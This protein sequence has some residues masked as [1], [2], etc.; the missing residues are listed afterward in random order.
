MEVEFAGRNLE[1]S[2]N[3]ADWTRI[4]D[5]LEPEEEPISSVAAEM[6]GKVLVEVFRRRGKR[7]LD[8]S[9]AFLRFL[10]LTWVI[11]ADLLDGKS[12]MTLADEVGVTRAALSKYSVE[13]S[14]LLGG[15]RNG[16][17]K[18]KAARETYREIQKGHKNY[19]RGGTQ[20]NTRTQ[21]RL[22][23]LRLDFH[24]GRVWKQLD[25]DLLR[26]LGLIG[27]GDRITAKGREWLKGALG[28]PYR[29]KSNTTGASLGRNL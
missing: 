19:R 29:P 2:G 18:S 24:E 10:A 5:I 1:D 25:R 26:R 16:A 20:I 21:E 27:A 8:Y 7:K 6:L 23:Q 14:D 13:F 9:A 4:E 17:Q 15:F 11:R 28:D 3:M 22:T 12:L